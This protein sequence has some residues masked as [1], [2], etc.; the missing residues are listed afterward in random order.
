MTEI[1]R[2]L[3]SFRTISEIVPIDGADRVEIAK[4]DGWQVVTQKGWAEPGKLVIYFEVDSFLPIR[5][6]FEFLRKSGYRAHPDLGEGFK[7][8][9]IKLRG[10]LSQGLIMP[11]DELFPP[12]VWWGGT[13][14][15]GTWNSATGPRYLEFRPEP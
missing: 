10:E 6:E 5:P 14:K 1:T 9:T 11:F 15:W 8:K 7:L 12:M 2:K 4:I 3:A 13:G